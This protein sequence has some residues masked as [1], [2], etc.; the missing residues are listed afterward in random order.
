MTVLN[1][2][3]LTKSN[4]TLNVV[5]V[6]FII[7]M[8]VGIIGLISAKEIKNMDRFGSLAVVCAIIWISL[9]I[10]SEIV[11]EPTGRYKI[12]ATFSDDMPFLAVME[13]YDIVE[14]R[15]DIFVLE[16]KERSIEE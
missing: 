3:E 16:P 10:A 6:L 13:E 9:L 14:Q 5:A 8:V 7:G 11:G 2:V 1:M 12:E 4:T 15:G